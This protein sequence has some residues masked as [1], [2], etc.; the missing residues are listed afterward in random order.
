M[1]LKELT[2]GKSG[3]ELNPQSPFGRA[4]HAGSGFDHQAMYKMGDLVHMSSGL[5]RVKHTESLSVVLH[6]GM[7]AEITSTGS[8]QV[9]LLITESDTDLKSFTIPKGTQILLGSQ[10]FNT[11]NQIVTASADASVSSAKAVTINTNETVRQ[12]QFKAGHEATIL[13]VPSGNV[14]STN[15]NVLLDKRTFDILESPSSGTVIYDLSWGISVH[16]KFVRRDGK[17]NGAELGADQ[18]TEMSSST[19]PQSQLGSAAL[20]AAGS[21]NTSPGTSDPKGSV[22]EGARHGASG[23]GLTLTRYA[24]LISPKVRV[25]QPRGVVRFAGDRD[26]NTDADGRQVNQSGFL[27]AMDT[28]ILLPNPSYQ[29]VTGSNSDDATLPFFQLLQDNFETMRDPHIL[30]VGMKLR[31][32]PVSEEEVRE[33]YRR[34]GGFKSKLIQDPVQAYKYQSDSVTG[35]AGGWKEVVEKTRGR[36]L[37]YEE[38]KDATQQLTSQ[39]RNILYGTAG[40]DTPKKADPR[41]EHRGMR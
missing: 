25:F 40:A 32:D 13:F 31:L 36:K 37:S 21:R 22:G 28:S 41:R 18:V 39:S 30:L 9:V 29:I 19:D 4:P 2:K 11:D 38:Y 17:I 1:A 7:S 12:S 35:P 10:G 24:G 15:T 8:T 33:M 20:A 27:T 3:D 23:Y 5:Y 14:D 26:K 16:P 6:L 34:S